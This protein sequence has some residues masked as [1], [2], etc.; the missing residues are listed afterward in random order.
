[1]GDKNKSEFHGEIKIEISVEP[2]VDGDDE[3][4][5]NTSL[6]ESLMST[7]IAMR[8]KAL[9]GASKSL[10]RLGLHLLNEPDNKTQKQ[11]S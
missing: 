11:E 2:N 6:S 4:T 7:P 1:M 3:M 10:G 9:E 5:I 8:L